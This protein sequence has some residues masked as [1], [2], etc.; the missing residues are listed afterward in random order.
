MTG[1][2]TPEQRIAVMRELVVE[3][4]G[5]N[6]GLRKLV[7]VVGQGREDLE[8]E[9]IR[10]A[11]SAVGRVIR[12]REWVE[13]GREARVAKTICTELRLEIRRHFAG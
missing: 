10:L 6:N 2:A 3:L 7:G 11:E 9:M 1:C 13:G 4:A 5:E 8:D 12:E